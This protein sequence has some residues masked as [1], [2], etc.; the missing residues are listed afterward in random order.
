V[1]AFIGTDEYK[2][3]KDRRFRQGDN[4]TIA[5]NEAFAL[6]DAET[7]RLFART[8]QQTSALYYGTKPTFEQILGRIGEWIN[9]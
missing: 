5:R 6:R 7:R 2:A 3:H 8:F 4:K 9:R 1:Q